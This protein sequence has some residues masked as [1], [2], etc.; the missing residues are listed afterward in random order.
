MNTNTQK[1]K[2]DRKY[3]FWYRISED[4]LLGNTKLLNQNEY[5]NQVKKIAEFETVYA[6]L[7]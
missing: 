7:I 2:L 4:A 5:E 3:C 1:T 6:R